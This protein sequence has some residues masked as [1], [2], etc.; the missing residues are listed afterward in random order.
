MKKTIITFFISIISILS[1]TEI[2]NAQSLVLKDR[3]YN[4]DIRVDGNTLKDNNYNT[5]ARIDGDV[6]K[7]NNYNVIARI[8]GDVVKDRNYNVIGRLDGRPSR[9]QL[10]A[11]LY[12][13]VM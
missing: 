9:T 5:I 13:L 3:N 10:L 7:D 1:F 6:I 12:F 8:D 2:S 4:V 11:M